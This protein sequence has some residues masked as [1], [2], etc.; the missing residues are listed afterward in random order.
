MTEGGVVL[1]TLVIM[2]A[3][4]VFVPLATRLG[5]SSILGYLAAGAAIGPW[6]LG[7]ITEVEEIRHFSEFGVVFLLFIIGIEMKPA[8][9]WLMRRQVFGLGGAQVFITGAVIGLAGWLMGLTPPVALITG[10]GLA[11]SSTAMGLQIL[12]E[13]GEVASTYGRA[14]FAV[15][16]LQDL[17]VPVLLTLTPLLAQTNTALSADVGKAVAEAAVVLAGAVLVGRFLLRPLFRAVAKTRSA[18]VFTA[19]ALLVVLGM[20]LAMEHVGLSMALGAFVAGLLLAESEFR[21]Q[22]EADI[23]PFRGLLLGLFF[24][25]VGMSVDFGLLTESLLLVIALVF[26]LMAVKVLILLPLLRIGGLALPDALKGAALLGQGGEFAFVLFSFALGEGVMGQDVVQLLI[27]VVSLSMALTPL[28]MLLGARAAGVLAARGEAPAE[29]PPKPPAGK[30][31]HVIVC[32]FGRV[33]QTVARLLEDQGRA[34]IAFDRDLDRVMQGRSSGMNVYFGDASRAE[35]LHAAHAS[36]ARLVVVTTDDAAATARA[37]AQ[38]HHHYPS[39]PIHARARDLGQSHTL[40]RYGATATVPETLESSLQLAA[41]VL[42]ATGLT[43]EAVTDVLE[44]WR[45]D[46]YRA[47]REA[48]DAVRAPEG[49]VAPEQKADAG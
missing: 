5:M 12:A 3:A 17:M 7:F 23:Q 9:L 4:V 11:L 14:A 31:G 27:L 49:P 19:M 1:D 47:L 39:L 29:T 33:G 25:A 16:L 38:I 45:A 2:G 21:H 32:G 24:M 35:V 30:E 36:D 37:V 10:L 20:A 18:E 28:V 46:D 15:L 44:T 13:R 48:V 22:V 34:Y 41:S 40:R 42:T 26:G 8:R 43:A 6:G